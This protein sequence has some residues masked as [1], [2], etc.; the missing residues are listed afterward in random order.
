MGLLA[1]ERGLLPELMQVASHSG[2]APMPVPLPSLRS[3][4]ATMLLMLADMIS[5]MPQRLPLK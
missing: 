5:N 3:W 2:D 4:H 1:W